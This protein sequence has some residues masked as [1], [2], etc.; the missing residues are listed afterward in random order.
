VSVCWHGA[1][2]GNLN[3]ILF[4]VCSSIGL[5]RNGCLY[6][7]QNSRVDFSNDTSLRRWVR[8]SPGVSRSPFH[9]HDMVG[10]DLHGE[11]FVSKT[12]PS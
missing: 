11:W 2:S 3:R 5:W 12:T 8:T 9:I 6:Q 7:N 4:S 1:S 10:V